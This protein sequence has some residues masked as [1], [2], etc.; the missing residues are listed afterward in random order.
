MS[1]GKKKKDQCDWW[2][3]WPNMLKKE[4]A[5]F[6]EHGASTKALRRSNGV[7]IL[8]VSWPRPSVEAI[9]LRVGFSPLHPFMRPSVSAPALKLQRHQN[10][11]THELCLLTQE[12][13]Q[14]NPR[15]TVA[16]FIAIQLEKIFAALKRREAQDWCAAAEVEENA[17]DPL[18]AYF[19][20][21]VDPGSVV[22]FARDIN[23]PKIGAGIATVEMCQATASGGI[24]RF[25][26]IV[27][28][29]GVSGDS[30]RRVPFRLPQETGQWS[31]VP[32]RWVRLDPPDTLDVTELLERAE[33]EI[34]RQLVVQPKAQTELKNIGQANLSITIIVFSEEISYG[35]VETGDGFLF[36]VH[37]KSGGST[38]T[39]TFLA[40]GYGISDDVFSRLPCST[41]LRQKR[42]FIVGCGAIGGFV[43]TELARAGFGELS[44]IDKDVLEPG[45]SVRHV[46]GREYWGV[47]KSIAL[48]LFLQRNHPFTTVTPWQG[49]IGA[50]QSDVAI[51]KVDDKNHLAWLEE[52]IS[53]A[54]IVIDASAETECQHALAHYCRTL[55]KPLVVGYA[56]LGA[57]G[58]VVARFRPDRP[59]CYVCLQEHWE[60]KALPKPSVD[61]TGT[62]LPVGCNAPTFTGG[63]FDLQEVSLE[64]ARSAIGIAAPDEYDSGDWDLAVLS[65]RDANNRRVLP[66]WEGRNFE[67]HFRCTGHE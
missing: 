10:L 45:N 54:D 1:R 6:S 23:I 66:H 40:R 46:L 14:W 59:G 38:G 55:D 47:N 61:P 12:S 41:S 2:S 63:A 4:L 27:R 29:V 33:L 62:V 50:A 19:A 5:A 58:G 30:T 7:L 26:A 28:E 56:T 39:S 51:S 64:V 13:G 18:S 67:P 52:Q 48:K 42:A 24:P 22:Y 15:Q 17:P 35:P 8:S 57:A 60:D 43:A 31:S 37:Q 9:E 25:E 53:K 44:I 16:E 32:A 21:S 65:L 36:L 11:F 20:S 34:G 3:R 49:A